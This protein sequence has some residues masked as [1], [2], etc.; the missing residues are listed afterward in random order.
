MK[1]PKSLD[2]NIL[3][4]IGETARLVHKQITIIFT[5]RG[6]DVTA[7]QFGVLAL[8]WYKEGVKQQYIAD[9][10]NRDKTTITRIIKNMMNRDLIV[11]VPDKLDKRNKLIYLTPKGKALQKEMVE[12]SGLIYYQALQNIPPE[13]IETCLS[14]L[15]QIMKNLQCFS[16]Y[17]KQHIPLII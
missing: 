11:K 7:E 4:L 8:L 16:K 15:R 3:Y 14:I 13:K 6:F 2:E 9:H 12:S 1:D 17:N 10:L 5:K